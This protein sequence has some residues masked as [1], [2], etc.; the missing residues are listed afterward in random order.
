MAE[1]KNSVLFY[2][3]VIHVV[4]ELEDDEAGRLFKHYLRYI[5]DMN[6]TAPDKLTQVVFE[7]IK[8]NLKRDLKKWERIKEKRSDAGKKSAELK[9]SSKSVEQYP[10]NSTLVESV[11]QDSTNS[12]VNDNVNVTVNVNGN[13]TS[14]K[15]ANALVVEKS[16][17]A[18]N[19]AK[20][21][22]EY[23]ELID[24]ISGRDLKTVW[25]G[26]KDFISGN[27]PPF[28][29]PYHEVWNLFAANFGLSK[30]EVI[31]DTRRKKFKTRIEEPAFDFLKI[32]EKIK[33]SRMLKGVDTKND[34]KVTFDWIFENQSN[35]VKILEGNY[36]GN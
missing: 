17:T 10:T 25:N 16:T 23:Q 22:I 3:D 14:N 21:K 11:E 31:N 32:L 28:I 4:E 33:G 18:Q 12:T 34:W 7:P 20:L 26:L 35:Y 36:D 19:N 8:Q 24:T 15:R 30:I 2:C 5:N 1:D 13:V 9:K 27:S 29:E 6:P